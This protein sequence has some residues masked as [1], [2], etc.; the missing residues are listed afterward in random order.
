[1]PGAG[2]GSERAQLTLCRRQTNSALP[3]IG[4]LISDFHLSSSRSCVG[5]LL[6][7]CKV[8]QSSCPSSLINGKFLLVP[9][10]DLVQK[11]IRVASYT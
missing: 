2:G 4:T 10:L 8:S 1:M 9:L 3:L 6:Q 7:V 5:Y 11:S